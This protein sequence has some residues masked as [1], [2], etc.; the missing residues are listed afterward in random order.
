MEDDGPDESKRELGV[1]VDDVLAADV[2]QLDLL[3][4]QEPQRRLHVLDRVEPHSAALAGKDLSGE[5]LQQREQVVAISEV[6]EEVADVATG[7]QIHT[8]IN[9]S[10]QNVTILTTNY[11]AK[12][13]LR[14]SVVN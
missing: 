4:P 2:D 9:S 10:R 11:R 3:V 12:C 7:L 5:D 13:E 6:F 1:P 8:K 14:K